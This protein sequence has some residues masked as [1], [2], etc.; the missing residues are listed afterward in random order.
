MEMLFA[1]YWWLIFPLFGMGMGLYGMYMGHKARQDRIGLIR[2]YLEQGKEPPPA[3]FEG[4]NG[5]DDTGC[6]SQGSGS[7]LVAMVCVFSAFTLAFGYVGWKQDSEV[8]IALGLGFA[9]AAVISLIM[10]LVKLTR[11]G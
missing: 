7:N 9:P 8:Y 3:L 10:L 4:L 1:H 6:K 2:H 5:P 11:K